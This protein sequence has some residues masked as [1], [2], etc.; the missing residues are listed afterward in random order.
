MSY[1]E[2]NVFNGWKKSSIAIKRILRDNGSFYL[3]IGSKPTDQWIAWDVANVLREH[4]VL[5]NTIHWI[6]SIGIN[7]SNVENY[8]NITGDIAV[9]ISNNSE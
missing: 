9:D 8:P 7:K 1:Q 6:K 4:F 2:R 3:N 5:Q